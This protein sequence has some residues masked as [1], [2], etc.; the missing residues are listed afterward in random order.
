[1]L[2][3]VFM[4][5]FVVLLAMSASI[6]LVKVRRNF[7]LHSR[8]QLA[9]FVILVITVAA[10]EIELQFFTN[11]RELAGPSPFYAS[12]WVDRVLAVHLCFSIPTPILWLVTVVLGL[13]WFGW[14]ARPNRNSRRHRFLGW[15]GAVFTALTTITGWI[16]YYLAFVAS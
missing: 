11:W 16:F 12:G 4:A 8:I 14:N 13:R 10:F 1:M 9:L 5:T 7:R 6:Y 3:V 15:T 2:D